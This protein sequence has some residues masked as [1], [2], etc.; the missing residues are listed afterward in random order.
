L[1]DLK[2]S[3]APAFDT[4]A[5]AKINA[6]VEDCLRLIKRHPIFDSYGSARLNFPQSK[7][8]RHSAIP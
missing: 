4:L 7:S 5:F 3:V 2:V 1:N 8:P 6:L